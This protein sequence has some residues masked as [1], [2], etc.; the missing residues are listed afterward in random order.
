MGG[1][2]LPEPL[3]MTD[4]EL[5]VKLRKTILEFNETARTLHN[6][7]WKVDAEVKTHSVAP[8]TTHTFPA[9]Q[10]YGITKHRVEHL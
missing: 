8:N 6:R 9:L 7:G 5:A 3:V 1:F 2:G 4:Q 10:I